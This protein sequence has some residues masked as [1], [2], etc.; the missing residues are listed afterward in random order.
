MRPFRGSQYYRDLAEDCR[1]VAEVGPSKW[2]A[3]Y[4]GSLN[5]TKPLPRKWKRHRVR[6]LCSGASIGLATRH[7]YAETMTGSPT[8]PKLL[9]GASARDGRLDCCTTASQFS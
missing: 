2:K 9:A 6:G 3:S 8:V 7:G 4:F 1:T 5:P